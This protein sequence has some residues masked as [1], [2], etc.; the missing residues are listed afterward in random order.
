MS[1]NNHKSSAPNPYKGIYLRSI[2][3]GV[4]SFAVMFLI[5]RTT[6]NPA[7]SPEKTVNSA[8]FF[9]LVSPVFMGG[10]IYLAERRYRMYEEGIGDYR[11]K[12]PINILIN[13]GYLYVGRTDIYLVFA[14]TRPHFISSVK[15]TNVVKVTLY[16]TDNINLTLKSRNGEDRSLYNIKFRVNDNLGELMK[17]FGDLFEGRVEIT[18]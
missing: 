1:T 3:V 9:A 6:Q 8:F 15:M 17:I 14:T 18:D 11:I 4:S 2:M 10:K 5:Y 13:K 7:F 16:D 12:V